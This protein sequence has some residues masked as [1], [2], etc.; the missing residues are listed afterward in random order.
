[1]DQVKFVYNRAVKTIKNEKK[2]KA[3]NDIIK[4]WRCQYC[5]KKNSTK[6]Q[7]CANCLMNK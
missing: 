5:Q 7:Y 1:M 3:K 2:V 4:E 6:I